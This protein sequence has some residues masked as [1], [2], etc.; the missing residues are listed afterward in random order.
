MTQTTALTL[1]SNEFA[2]KV[3]KNYRNIAAETAIAVGHK[4]AM[5]AMQNLAF[6]AAFANVRHGRY[7]AAVEILQFAAAPAQYKAV[8]PA[9]GNWNKKRIGMLVEMIL[10]RATPK[11]GKWT[12]KALIGRH[13][14]H[15]IDCLLEGKPLPPEYA[16]TATEVP[17]KAEET[18]PATV[19]AADPLAGVAAGG[20]APAPF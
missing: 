12:T 11:S 10:G 1:P 3:G 18:A 14:A 16:E 5:L 9:D 2:L 13:M 4:E 17:T 19:T 15:L 20:N 8:A 6:K 7:R